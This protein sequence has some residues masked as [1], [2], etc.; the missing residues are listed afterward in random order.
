MAE[1]TIVRIGLNIKPRDGE[2]KTGE[3]SGASS[4]TMNVD[5]HE[6]AFLYI[7]QSKSAIF[8]EP[9]DP[10]I[11]YCVIGKISE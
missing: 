8:S 6:L 9:G 2:M 7:L 1:K 11:S 10:V 5:A 4:F 3:L